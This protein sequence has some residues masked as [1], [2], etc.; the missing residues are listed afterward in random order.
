MNADAVAEAMHTCQTVSLIDQSE[1]H[2]SSDDSAKPEQIVKDSGG[3]S[4]AARQLSES[5]TTTAPDP[6]LSSSTGINQLSLVLSSTMKKMLINSS[7]L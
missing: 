5:R 2:L 6:L 7:I 3:G 4:L 1:A